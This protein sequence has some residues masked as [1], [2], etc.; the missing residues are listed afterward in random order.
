VIT[1]CAGIY[2]VHR[3][4]ALSDR[5]NEPPWHLWLWLTALYAA[6]TASGAPA[7]LA[8]EQAYAAAQGPLPD[9][10]QKRHRSPGIRP[11]VL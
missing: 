1:A 10:R 7:I 9:Q 11:R 4:A 6:L 3:D 8:P 2:Q 5:P